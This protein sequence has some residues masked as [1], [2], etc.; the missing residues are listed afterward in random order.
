MLSRQR[1]V[2][3]AIIASAIF[4]SILYLA[5]ILH[6]FA[7]KL[8]TGNTKSLCRPIR[9]PE[10][11]ESNVTIVTAYFELANYNMSTK[12]ATDNFYSW[13]KGVLGLHSRMIIFT[14]TEAMI[15]TRNALAPKHLTVSVLVNFT[16]LSTVRFFSPL[17]DCY[18]F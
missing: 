10:I 11:G 2:R 8:E 4:V 13:A 1:N 15:A 7:P 6:E 12:H 5:F 3:L 16:R 18:S 9:V 17:V 14:D